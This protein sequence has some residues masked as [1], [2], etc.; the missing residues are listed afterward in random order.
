MERLTE[1]RPDPY[2]FCWSNFKVSIDIV[3]YEWKISLNVLYF[4]TV[5]NSYDIMIMFVLPPPT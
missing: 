3:C 5:F 2:S 4:S 1:N